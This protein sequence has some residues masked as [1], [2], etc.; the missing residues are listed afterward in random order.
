MIIKLL[1]IV[2]G[3]I[4]IIYFPSPQWI[5]DYLFDIIIILRPRLS[6]LRTYELPLSDDEHSISC[7]P[8]FVD[9]VVSVTVELIEVGHQF[10]GQECV[11][12]LA[13]QWYL[14]DEGDFVG[15]LSFLNI[16]F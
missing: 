5:I 3:K 15:Y 11:R 10:L 4:L 7:L 6:L 1:G 12:E 2:L 13:E 8:L 14:F 16:F 9:K